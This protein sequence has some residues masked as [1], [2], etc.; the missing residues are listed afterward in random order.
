MRRPCQNN[1]I[2]VT[3]NNNFNQ[4]VRWKND[5]GPDIQSRNYARKDTVIV[6]FGGYTIIRF[7]V[8]NPGWWFIHCHIEVHQLGGM[9]AVIRELPD[10]WP[11]SPTTLPISP[12]SSRRPLG[13]FSLMIITALITAIAITYM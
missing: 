8:N 4:T 13:S 7:E 9:A 10:E 6:P 5:T 2:T 1:F 11:K 3:G 12:C